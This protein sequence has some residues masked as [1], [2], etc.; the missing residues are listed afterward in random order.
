[1]RIRNNVF[2]VLGL[3]HPWGVNAGFVVTDGGV[4]VIDSG[5]TYYSALT[6]LGYIKSVAGDKPIKY[7][8]W[9]EHHSD[10]IFGSI[11]FTREGAEVIAHKNAYVFLKEIGGIRGYVKFM[12]EKINNEYKALV[13]RGF[14]IGSMIFENVEDVWP[15]IL[16][17]KEYTFTLGDTEFRL[18]P[19]PGHTPSNIVVYIPKHKVLFAGDTIYSKYP[20]NTRFST[21]EL[22]EN[23][24]KALDCIYT[25][26]IEVI[27][28]GHGPPCSKE[29][30]N[31]IK[32]I[33]KELMKDKTHA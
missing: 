20:P 7:L 4:V 22:I 13:E 19:T 27:I 12:K 6:I 3:H 31:R 33:L 15:S 30:I 2:A 11:V 18:I 25:L 24:I 29:E 1:M 17:D 9:T 26:N 5:W 21:Q 32:A 14:D 28:P 16:I 10:H 8:I 23:W